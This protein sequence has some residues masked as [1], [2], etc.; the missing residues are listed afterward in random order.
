MYNSPWIVFEV[1]Q[2]AKEAE[3]ERRKKGRKCKDFF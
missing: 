2:G 1:R 3:E